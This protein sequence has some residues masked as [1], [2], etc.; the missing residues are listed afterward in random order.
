MIIIIIIIKSLGLA[1]CCGI[2]KIKHFLLQ[3]NN[4]NWGGNSKSASSPQPIFFFFPV[5]T[6]HPVFYSLVI[7]LH[8]YFYTEF[9]YRFQ[10]NQQW[11][12][13]THSTLSEVIAFQIGSHSLSACFFS[14]LHDGTTVTSWTG[15]MRGTG[16]LIK[17]VHDCVLHL[18]LELIFS[19]LFTHM[20]LRLDREK[21][22]TLEI[23]PQPWQCTSCLSEHQ[24]QLRKTSQKVHV[25]DEDWSHAVHF[26][27]CCVPP[28]PII[29]TP[30]VNEEIKN[31]AFFSC[32]LQGREIGKL[33]N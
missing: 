16:W 17:F 23:H 25:R 12:C 11:N 28:P 18:C 27:L 30:K 22:R 9:I 1:N 20:L 7:A 19:A 21:A 8:F 6:P 15:G 2:R 4:Q 33:V 3:E 26:Q 10:R 24:K 13:L 5:T 29:L 14:P 32:C 31:G